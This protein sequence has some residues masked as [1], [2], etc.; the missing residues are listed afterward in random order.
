[1]MLAILKQ[2]SGSQMSR[3]EK[4]ATSQATAQA[5]YGGDEQMFGAK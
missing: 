2:A 4:T 1:M 5:H 3:F